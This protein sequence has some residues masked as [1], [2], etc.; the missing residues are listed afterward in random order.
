MAPASTNPSVWF[1][2][3]MAHFTCKT[4]LPVKQFAIYYNA[5]AQAGTQGNNNKILHLFRTP[6]NHLTNGS[7]IGI[8]GKVNRYTEMVF[9]QFAEFNLAFPSQICSAFDGTCI[10]IGIGR[11]NSNTHKF[12]ITF[13]GLDTIFYLA[14]Q[15]GNKI[16][17]FFM[18]LGRYRMFIHNVSIAIY[19]T[20]HRICSTYV[21]SCCKLLHPVK[22][23]NSL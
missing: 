12:K 9:N 14:T 8:V 13:Q 21:H 19:D 3:N 16:F 22:L 5:T 1:H 18:S 2:D 7:S 11:T 20:N 15:F 6:V 23:V 4:I 17:N 10:K